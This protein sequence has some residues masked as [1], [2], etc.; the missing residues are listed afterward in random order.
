MAFKKKFSH[1]TEAALHS[2]AAQESPRE[3]GVFSILFPFLRRVSR[4][5]FEEEQSNPLM[6]KGREGGV[7][8]W[9]GAL[10]RIP[11]P[12]LSNRLARTASCLDLQDGV[13]VEMEFNINID[14][15]YL[16]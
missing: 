13:V 5:R 12:N 8:E 10:F 4:F 15:L 7:A 3:E 11:S 16:N 14:E 9:D 1:C 6:R 2:Q